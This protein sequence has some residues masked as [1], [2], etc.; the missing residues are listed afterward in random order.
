MSRVGQWRMP[1]SHGKVLVIMEERGCPYFLFKAAINALRNR[2]RSIG[3]S[4]SAPYYSNRIS[5]IDPFYQFDPELLTTTLFKFNI[6]F[7]Q[8]RKH[9]LQHNSGLTPLPPLIY[10]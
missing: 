8:K 4:Q 1:D 6:A 7:D 3:T 2:A 10:N 9:S 5:S